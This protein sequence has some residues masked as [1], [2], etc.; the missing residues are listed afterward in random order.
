MTGLT[1]RTLRYYDS[2]GILK[3][4]HISESG[5]R[6]YSGKELERLQQIMLYRKMDMKLEDIQEILNKADF[7]PVLAL[8]K[9]LNVLRERMEDLKLHMEICE[10]SIKAYKGEIIMK[11]SERFTA[12]KKEKISENERK[13]GKEVREKYG[14]E[15]ADKSN[16]HFMNISEEDYK[17]SL[18]AQETLF[19]ELRYFMESGD[20]DFKG[21]HGKNAF[22]AH[23]EWLK[24]VNPNYSENYHRALGDMYGYDERFKKYYEARAGKGSAEIIREIILACTGE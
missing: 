4:P 24:I 10:K 8:E 16:A 14:S 22:T 13:F 11:D 6:Y 2:I 7:D 18:E 1:G 12:F 15:A 17:K 19:N 9:H 20:M 5:Y 21:V 3:P 23:R